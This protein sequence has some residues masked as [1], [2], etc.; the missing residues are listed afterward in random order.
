MT[1]ICVSKLAIIASD[2]GLSPGRRQAIIW[3]NAG[4]LLIGTLGT[5]FSEI[6]CK[7]HTFSFKKINLKMS[8]GKWRPFCLGLNELYSQPFCDYHYS[9]I[10]PC[11]QSCM[12]K[13]QKSSVPVFFL[14]SLFLV[15]FHSPPE[16]DPWFWFIQHL[17]YGVYNFAIL[18]CVSSSSVDKSLC[19]LRKIRLVPF[20]WSF[21]CMSSANW[22][23]LCLGLS[24][25]FSVICLWN[26][27]L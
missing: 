10:L 23:P 26:T 20:A 9:S 4:L 1:H 15:Y 12:H 13:W 5:N 6:L 14:L 24:R 17:H 18:L 3:T 7:V 25:V 16:Q 22:W 21:I 2:N 19:V 27:R 8:S 11:S